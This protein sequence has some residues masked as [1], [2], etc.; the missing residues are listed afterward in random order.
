MKNKYYNLKNMMEL[1]DAIYR[2]LF[3]ERSNG[4]SYAVTEYALKR[5][6]TEK[7]FYGNPVNDYMFC[8]LRRWKEEIKTKS[9][10]EYFSD[11]ANMIYKIT[12]G[13]YNHISVYQSSIYFSYL[14][15]ETYEIT[16]GKEIGKA[17]CLTS[18]THYKSL[19]YP[20]IGMV[21]FEEFITDTYLPSEPTKLMS[22]VSTIARKRHIDVFLIGN[23]ISRICPYFREWAL[24]GI[25]K[26]K[27]GTIDLYNYHGIDYSVQ[28]AVE[29]CSNSSEKN[30]IIIGK[31]SKM[32]NTGIWDSDEYPHIPKK[33]NQ[34]KSLYRIMLV[35]DDFKYILE[36]LQDKEDRNLILYVY[37]ATNTSK[38]K[39]VISSIFTTDI[40]TTPY[41][42][43]L[44]KYD[45]VII[46]LL[47]SN[48]IVYSD[49]LTGTEF[50]NIIKQKGG[51][52]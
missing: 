43:P 52:L 39:R 35:Y 30:T 9:V 44:T 8:Y 24:T 13:K 23:S 11:K 49:N 50:N 26:Q 36:L 31:S 46:D 28:I 45:K 18:E 48:K 6:W 1:K 5:A 15:P 47:D 14:D 51:R 38:C 2:L 25:L 17:M 4:K 7:D 27:Q 20:A 34:Y 12:N 40:M 37:P 16:R 33:Y 42:K 19:Q 3:G 29:Y 21:I 41:L 22:I 32:I 10:E